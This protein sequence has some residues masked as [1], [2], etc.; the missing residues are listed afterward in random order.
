MANEFQK[1]IDKKLAQRKTTSTPDTDTSKQPRT[2][3]AKRE[4]AEFA[5]IIFILVP[6][7]NMFVM[8]SY[9]IPTSSMEAEM[10]VGDRLFVS[11]LHY[12]PRIPQTPLALPYVHNKMPMSSR[13]SFVEWLK[14]PYLRLPGLGKVD[15]NDIVVFNYP[16]DK[17]LGLPVDKREN[18][19]KRC[20]GIAGDTLSV[21]AGEVYINGKQSLHPPLSQYQYAVAVDDPDTIDP[22]FFHRL[23][24]REVLGQTQEGKIAMLLTEEQ[25]EKLKTAAGVISVNKMLMPA[26]IPDPKIYPQNPQSTWNV[27]NFGPLYLPKRGDQIK[28]DS[29]NYQ[30]YLPVIRDYEGKPNAQWNAAEQRLYIDG[31]ATDS[32]QF[33]MDYYF[34]M[35]DNRHNSLDSRFWGLVP[36]DHI[37]GTPFFVWLSTN[38]QAQGWGD[39][40]RWDKSF[41]LVK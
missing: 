9:A 28:I 1:N 5:F 40:V 41:R 25:A 11:K 24:V 12:G 27:D 16:G 20:T 21:V 33:T 37:V 7:I 3:S 32:Y 2:K 8:Q 23:G 31:K 13:R 29:A 38:D 17:T 14:L 35:G 4:I 30:L 34:M 39:W 19:I 36:E 6:F 10:L 18:Y 15:R 22:Q 26:G